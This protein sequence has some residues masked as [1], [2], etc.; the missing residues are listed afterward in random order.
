M[1]TDNIFINLNPR[2]LDRDSSSPKSAFRMTKNPLI[3]HSKR[4]EES[5][6]L[7]GRIINEGQ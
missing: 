4:S 7:I 6:A 1:V 3:C 2:N 5:H